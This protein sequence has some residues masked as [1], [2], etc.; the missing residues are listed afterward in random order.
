MPRPFKAQSSGG[1]ERLFNV[2]DA[3]GV[4]EGLCYLKAPTPPVEVIFQVT[5]PTFPPCS[6]K[7][8]RKCDKSNEL[9]QYYASSPIATFTI[10]VVFYVT[11]IYPCGQIE[12]EFQVT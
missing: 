4:I 1:G 2:S 6:S 9:T 10:F 11:W 7:D 5:L 12:V 8:V 3:L